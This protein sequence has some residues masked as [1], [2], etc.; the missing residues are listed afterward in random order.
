[1]ISHSDVVSIHSYT[2]LYSNV[3]C[4]PVPTLVRPEP[5]LIKERYHS[6]ILSNDSSCH[7][8]IREVQF[9]RSKTKDENPFHKLINLINSS[10]M[11]YTYIIK[12]NTIQTK[13]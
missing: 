11:V 7:Y 2:L 10:F 3:I 6:D 9:L 12:H 8:T 5:N 13:A 4:L 1:M